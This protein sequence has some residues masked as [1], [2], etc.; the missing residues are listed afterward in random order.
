MATARPTSPAE[1][2]KSA[3]GG[4]DC[5]RAPVSTQL[6]GPLGLRASAGWTCAWAKTFN[7]PKEH[8]SISRFGLTTAKSLFYPSIESVPNF[9]VELAA[10]LDKGNL[11]PLGGGAKVLDSR[12]IANLLKGWFPR[13]VPPLGRNSA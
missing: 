2:W 5:Q 1:R 13:F 11:I 6:S 10:S 7:A 4:R 9:A 8:R 12:Q 3:S